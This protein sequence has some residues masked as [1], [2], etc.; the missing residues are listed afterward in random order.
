MST[1][2]DQITRRLVMLNADIV[3]Y[4]RLVA[5]D[6]QAAIELLDH[7][8]VAIDRI[9]PAN[10]GSVVNFVGDNFL[11]AFERV[12]DALAAAIAICSASRS[13][14]MT[15]GLQPPSLRIGL[16][17]GE[18]AITD[19]GRYVGDA[20]NIAARVQALA[21]PA[22]IQVTE[23]VYQ[24]L[25]EPALRFAPVG[26][27]V[28]KGIPEPVR[29]YR[30]LHLD[31]LAPT[32]TRRVARNPTVAVLPATTYGDSNP[33]LAEMGRYEIMNQLARIPGLAIIE[34]SPVEEAATG[35]DY[36]IDLMLHG[37]GDRVRWYV[38]VIELATLNRVWGDRWEGRTDRPTEALDRMA[39]DVAWAFEVELVVG[40]P[41]TIYH[42]SLSPEGVQHVYLGWHAMSTGTKHGLQ[43][44]HAHFRQV[45]ALQSDAIAGFAL[46]AFSRWWAVS[47][48][49]SDDPEDDARI[50]RERARIG[51]ELG[52]D[53]GLSQMVMAAFEIGTDRLEAAMA[54]AEEALAKRPT[55][56][57]SFAVKGSILR[58]M[59]DWDDAVGMVE[60]AIK[61][62]PMAKPWYPTIMAS[63]LWVGERYEEAA[64]LAQEVVELTEDNPEALMILAASHAALGRV[65]R[66]AAAVEQLRTRH[67]DLDREAIL[68]AHPFQDAAIA[69]RLREHLGAAGLP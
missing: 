69:A 68:A 5:D 15:G 2:L 34:G 10:H 61:L 38:S 60:E 6:Q 27:R 11:A 21:D 25:D 65:R 28:L 17:A 57:V 41:A 36:T 54:A 59:G 55:C 35:A 58:Y 12:T 4:S 50:A 24:L 53:T 37:L 14:E 22:T 32:P 39:M 64:D 49:L 9:V 46:E 19:D 1:T 52:D 43:Q 63:A 62:S 8:Q 16:D 30:L 66:A 7:Y 48:N 3:G 56:D 29:I 18:V 23:A 20:V 67:P 44:A 47:Q 40:A 33:G 13:M 31:V 26:E 51:I 45:T 42:S